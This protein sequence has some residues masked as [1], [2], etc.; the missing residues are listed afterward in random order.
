MICN[1]ALVI[2]W[3]PSHPLDP[4]KRYGIRCRGC[5]CREASCR[6]HHHD[7]ETRR[8]GCC[9]CYF[10]IR[11]CL[12]RQAGSSLGA[13]TVDHLRGLSRQLFRSRCKH[14]GGS[15]GRVRTSVGGQTAGGHPALPGFAPGTRPRALCAEDLL[16]GRGGARQ[17]RANVIAIICARASRARK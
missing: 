13:H 4:A 16:Q 5:Q 17:V 10:I 15:I 14:A 1:F 9:G 11:C 8:P 3:K 6:R 12:L 7:P 2:C